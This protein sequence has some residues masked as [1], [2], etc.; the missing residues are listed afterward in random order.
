MGFQR[1]DEDRVEV[2]AIRESLLLKAARVSPA[3]I[4]ALPIIDDLAS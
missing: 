2:D 3:P 4:Q 1:S